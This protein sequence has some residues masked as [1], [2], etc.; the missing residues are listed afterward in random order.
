MAFSGGLGVEVSTYYRQSYRLWSGMVAKASQVRILLLML[1]A[2]F[3]VESSSMD[4]LPLAMKP[5]PRSSPG[6]C[7]P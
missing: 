4:L 5:K 2:S 1:L 3:S 6:P 7:K